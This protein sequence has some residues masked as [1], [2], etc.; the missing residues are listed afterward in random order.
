[1]LIA[2]NLCGS[3]QEGI[4]PTGVLYLH[5]ITDTHFGGTSLKNFNMFRKLCGDDMLKNVAVVTTIWGTVDPTKGNAREKHLRSSDKF[6]KPILDKGATMVR[7][8]NTAESA[9]KII[10]DIMQ[11]TRQPEALCIQRELVDEGKTINQTSAGQELNRTLVELT[12]TH[13]N[14]LR[15]IQ[16]RLDEAVRRNDEVSR[17]ELEAEKKRDEA[18]KQKAEENRERFSRG[19]NAATTSQRRI[20]RTKQTSTTSTSNLR[21]KPEVS[22][23]RKYVLAVTFSLSRIASIF[24]KIKIP[25]FR[26]CSLR[27]SYRRG[28]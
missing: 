13:E 16:R 14:E 7:H 22:G 1:M 24:R 3:Y 25:G 20:R 5:R 12:E 6:F 21:E 10:Q 26:G 2:T 28:D 8:D 15:D 27:G 11:K 18:E 19:N 23:W 4:R 17:R 9:K